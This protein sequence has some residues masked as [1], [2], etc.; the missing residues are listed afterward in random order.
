MLT[1]PTVQCAH[2]RRPPRH[3]RHVSGPAVMTSCRKLHCHPDWWCSHALNSND[4][5]GDAHECD[6]CFDVC[7]F[8]VDK[9]RCCAEGPGSTTFNAAAE[10]YRRMGRPTS[11]NYLSPCY[12]AY[13]GT[14]YKT[15][16]VLLSVCPC[17]YGRN[18]C[19]ILMHRSWGPEK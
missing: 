16:C 19:S 5:G 8:F 4:D 3:S 12:I 2:Q 15:T 17:S 10:F 9:R 7:A 1:A 6:S 13:H 14:D 18:F 11:F